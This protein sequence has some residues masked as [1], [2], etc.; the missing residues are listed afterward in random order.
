MLGRVGLYRFSSL[1]QSWETI[2]RCALPFTLRF[3]SPV[4]N[5]SECPYDL[6]GSENQWEFCQKSHSTVGFAISRF[7][8]CILKAKYVVLHPKISPKVDF[9]ML[10][11]LIDTNLSDERFRQ[12][13]SR[14]YICVSHYQYRQDS[15]SLAR[16]YVLCYKSFVEIRKHLLFPEIT[17]GQYG[18]S[19]WICGWISS[20][21][22][23]D[24]SIHFVFKEHCCSKFFLKASSC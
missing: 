5:D 14:H 19:H 6:R 10:L 12:I 16:I 15:S 13:N 1:R 2:S 7:I 17:L 18:Q 11:S 23:E 21:Q 24:K 4:G 8:V 22:R 9:G 3:Y 20:V